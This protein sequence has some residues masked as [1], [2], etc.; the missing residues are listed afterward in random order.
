M[1]GWTAKNLALDLVL[2]AELVENYMNWVVQGGCNKS[3]K[4]CNPV[5]N[6][7]V[8]GNDDNFIL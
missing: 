2:S 7:D 1:V 4:Q 6:E 5:L 3:T 8:T